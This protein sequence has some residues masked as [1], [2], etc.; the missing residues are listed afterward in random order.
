M[1]APYRLICAAGL[2]AAL[3]AVP[4]PSPLAAQAPTQT[5]LEVKYVRDADEYATLTR[6][7]YREALAAVNGSN[8]ARMSGPWSVVLDLDETVLDNSAYQLERAAYTLPFDDPSWNAWVERG[9]SGL[10]P[11][12]VEFVSGVRRLGGHIAWISNRAESTRAATVANLQRFNLWSDN[13]RLCLATDS[14]YPKKVRRSEVTDGRGACSWTGAPA[15]VVVYVG[16]QMG[17]FPAAG[18]SDPDAGKD[19]AF[20]RRFFILPNPMYGAWT[21]RVTRQ[22]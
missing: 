13:D 6:Q 9:E 14:T 20:G 17:D 16:D 22:R 10:V 12:V 19:D 3:F 11:G 2:G 1:F 4:A 7:V 21:T 15:P 5:R 18:E 8:R